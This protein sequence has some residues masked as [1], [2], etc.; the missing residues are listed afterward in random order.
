[1]G[2]CRAPGKILPLKE[3]NYSKIITSVK[4]SISLY[5]IE[6]L[7]QCG[8][9]VSLERILQLELCNYSKIITL[10]EKSILF[11]IIELFE[12]T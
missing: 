11:Y 3:C 4:K 12:T 10:A 8:V 2:G 1:M 7:K 6:M 9:A 5:F